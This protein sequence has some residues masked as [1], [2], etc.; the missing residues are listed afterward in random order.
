MSAIRAGVSLVQ[1]IKRKIPIKF[2]DD[3]L[4]MSSLPYYATP[5]LLLL[6]HF[7]I[8]QHPWALICIVNVLVP[9]LD[10]LFP[11]DTRS[12]NKK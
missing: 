10:E 12:P 5:L 3:K 4:L 11:Q 1:T 8:W 6:S 9:L 2:D 7:L